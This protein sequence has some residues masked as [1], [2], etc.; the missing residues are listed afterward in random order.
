MVRALRRR[1]PPWLRRRAVAPQ[2]GGR[3]GLAFVR[4][5]A[6]PSLLP[7][8]P[9]S[10]PQTHWGF[11][12]LPDRPP[13]PAGVFARSPIGPL[14][15][16][17]TQKAS[18]AAARALLAH[19]SEKRASA[20]AGDVWGA[21]FPV[22]P[23]TLRLPTKLWRLQRGRP[24]LFWRRQ[25]QSVTAPE[26]GEVLSITNKR[27][28]TFRCGDMIGKIPTGEAWL[29]STG[30]PHVASHMGGNK[31][32][33]KK[34]ARF[35]HILQPEE[36]QNMLRSLKIKNAEMGTLSLN[37]YYAIAMKPFVSHQSHKSQRT[38]NH[39]PS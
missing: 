26:R 38:A 16:P 36:L 15:R 1:P 22:P 27:F 8:A 31:S 14:S 29:N 23:A 13:K 12:S 18:A 35:E 34:G 32:P 7:L 39:L 25:K 30:R 19:K 21:S 3:G 28:T 9:R 17:A 4:P 20:E 11:R 24:R 10:A 6:A 37:F 5:P 2:V 33:C